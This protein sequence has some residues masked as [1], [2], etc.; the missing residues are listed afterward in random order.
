LAYRLDG[1]VRYL[2]WC[3]DVLERLLLDVTG[4]IASDATLAAA[5]EQAGLLNLSLQM[6]TPILHDLDLLA[7][8]LAMLRPST[9]DC[10]VL[11]EAWISSLLLVPRSA[12][13]IS[14]PSYREHRRSTRSC[15]GVT[16][17]P[18]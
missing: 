17:S 12:G 4:R 18:L 6:E 10:A 13:H 1:R 7:E 11:L 16:I 9:I 8:Q 14:I 15:S 3:D 2:L 5:V